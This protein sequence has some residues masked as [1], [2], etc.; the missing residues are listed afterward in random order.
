MSINDSFLIILADYLILTTYSDIL[1]AGIFK[2][3]G[4]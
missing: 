1:F 2:I 4:K 3:K